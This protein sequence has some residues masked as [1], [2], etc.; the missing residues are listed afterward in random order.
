MVSVCRGVCSLSHRVYEESHT[1]MDENHSLVRKYSLLMVVYVLLTG[2]E[3]RPQA[4]S[5]LQHPRESVLGGSGSLTTKRLGSRRPY[6]V[7][8]PDRLPRSSARNEP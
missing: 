2:G 5:S 3:Q 8:K 4:Y 1:Y 6:R 7:P